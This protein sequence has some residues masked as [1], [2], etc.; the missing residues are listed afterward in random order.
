MG[1]LE[2]TSDLTLGVPEI[3][4]AHQ[5][6]YGELSRLQ[7]LPDEEFAAGLYPFIAAL[8]RDFRSEETLMEAIDFPGLQTH[9][10]QHAH[11]LSAMHHLVPK[12]QRGEFTEAR[13]AIVLLPQWFQ[14]HVMTMDAVL[15]TAV[16][17]MRATPEE[18]G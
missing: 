3:D 6:L 4:E 15:A 12:L 5:T 9:R 14:M 1:Q 10:E 13:E 16:D 18:K 7:S 11:V 17:M 8:E 2:W